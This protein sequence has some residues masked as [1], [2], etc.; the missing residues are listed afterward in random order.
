MIDTDTGLVLSSVSQFERFEVLE[1]EAD[2]EFPPAMFEFDFPPGAVD[3]ASEPQPLIG[4]PAPSLAGLL[5]DGN[6]FDLADHRGERVAVLFWAT[7]CLPCLD[8][9]EALQSAHELWGEDILFV[10]VAFRDDP[11]QV[12]DVVD[13][14]ELTVLVLVAGED[15]R[16]ED[17]NVQGIPWLGLIHTDGTVIDARIGRE[18]YQDIF[19]II[20]NAPW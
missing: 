19:G 8:A 1:L 3:L 17:W 2:P 10:A 16:L 20:A 12:Q 7:W 4:Q 5:V 9:L 13:R 15:S 6:T 14:G 18:T 11:D